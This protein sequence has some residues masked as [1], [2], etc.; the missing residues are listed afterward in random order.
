MMMAIY[1]QIT[2]K[3][4]QPQVHGGKFLRNKDFLWR[5]AV[6]IATQYS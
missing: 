3:S 2:T 6:T 5:E 1:N 4:L